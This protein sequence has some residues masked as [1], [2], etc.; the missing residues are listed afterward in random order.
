MKYSSEYIDFSKNELLDEV[1]ERTN[2]FVLTSLYNQEKDILT[3]KV[4]YWAFRL[5]ISY[6]STLFFFIGLWIIHLLWG[7]QIKTFLFE[8]SANFL[9]STEIVYTVIDHFF[10]L[11]V[12]IVLILAIPQVLFIRYMVQH[13]NKVEMDF[14]ERKIFISN[15]DYIGRHF[16]QPQIVDFGEVKKVYT[17]DFYKSFGVHKLSITFFKIETST[18][19]KLTLFP[20]INSRYQDINQVRIKDIIKD[21]IKITISNN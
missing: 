12:I 18:N 16:S 3:F 4:G 19:I 21:L 15:L 11:V 10:I 9:Y 20:I 6:I 8:L 13:I 14:N 1:Q 5:L 17:K 2:F 7:D